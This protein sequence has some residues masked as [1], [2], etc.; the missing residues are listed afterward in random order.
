[1]LRYNL[2][3]YISYSKKK[4]LIVQITDSSEHYIFYFFQIFKEH[5]EINIKNQVKN[6]T[7]KYCLILFP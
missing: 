4:M 6:K 5:Q 3:Q 7:I 1:M 2:T